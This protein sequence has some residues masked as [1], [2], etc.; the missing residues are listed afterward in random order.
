MLFEWDESKREV[1]LAKHYI[2]FQDAK[3]GLR[4]GGVRERGKASR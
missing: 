4:R 1:H 3:T 2:D